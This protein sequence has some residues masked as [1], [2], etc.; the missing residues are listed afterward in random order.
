M[1]GLVAQINPSLIHEVGCGEGDI[2]SRYA[3]DG[4]ALLASDFSEQRIAKARES[5]KMKN[6][7]IKYMVR[8]IYELQ[9]Q[10]AA[11]LIVC[12]EVLEHLES[13]ERA[14]EI[15]SRIAKPY[16]IISVP[17]EPLWRMLNMLRGEYIR[18]LGNTPGHLQHFSKS[19]F[20]QLLSEH[21]EILKVLSPLPWTLVLARSKGG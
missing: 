20:L 17:R 15:L 1:D 16:L 5:A 12:S 3:R 8:N 19:A 21:F 18:H 11:P 14:V 2:I 10:D 13:P 6:V 9:E 7:Q 4:R